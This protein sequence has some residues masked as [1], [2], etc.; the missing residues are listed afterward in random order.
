MPNQVFVEKSASKK[1][2]FRVRFVAENG[3]QIGS[4]QLLTTRRNV[5][6][7]LVAHMGVFYGS[8][9]VV[10]DTSGKQVKKFS[11]GKDGMEDYIIP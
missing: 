9:C 8:H 2:P 3:E 6:K 10:I 11:L 4:P 7:N 1:K 5:I